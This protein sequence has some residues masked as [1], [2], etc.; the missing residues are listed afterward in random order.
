VTRGRISI[1]QTENN[2]TRADRHILQS[3]NSSR[4]LINK[5]Q[6]VYY[7][8]HRNIPFSASAVDLVNRRASGS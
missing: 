5:N 3:N 8:C 4:P 7:F 2:V 6:L 1:R